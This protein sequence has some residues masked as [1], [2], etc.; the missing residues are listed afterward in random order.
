MLYINVNFLFNAHLL[1]IKFLS[2][3]WHCLFIVATAQLLVG[4][5][6]TLAETGEQIIFSWHNVSVALPSA[7]LQ[8]SIR[9]N[10]EVEEANVASVER[11]RH[12]S[13]TFSAFH[14]WNCLPNC[15]TDSAWWSV[16]LRSWDNVLECSCVLSIDLIRG[17]PW[18]N[19]MAVRLYLGSPTQDTMV[20]PCVR[21]WTMSVWVYTRSFSV[22][23]K[24]DTWHHC[25]KNLLIRS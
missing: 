20:W 12:K 7:L 13:Q 9:S 24:K 11:R 5:V 6:V 21:W 8:E 18:T 15:C 19:E 16:V 4:T 14:F 23:H 25:N 3:K 1:L 10:K 17:R 22:I 2:T